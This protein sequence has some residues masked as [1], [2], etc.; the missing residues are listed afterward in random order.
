MLMLRYKVKVVV[1]SSSVE[2]GCGSRS[3]V[4]KKGEGSMM[5]TMKITMMTIMR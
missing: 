1:C 2:C 3:D 5:M 4:V